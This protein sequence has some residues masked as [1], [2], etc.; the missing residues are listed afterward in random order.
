MIKQ[1]KHKININRIPALIQ[2]NRWSEQRGNSYSNRQK[3]EYKQSCVNASR[4]SLH[5]SIR[6]C[7]YHTRTHNH[8]ENTTQYH[9]GSILKNGAKQQRE[10][11]GDAFDSL[12]FALSLSLSLSHFHSRR[13]ITLLSF[14]AI[15]HTHCS[16]KGRQRAAESN[17]IYSTKT[18]TDAL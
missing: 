9:T 15:T 13:R 4:L 6:T 16:N 18:L 10:H 5:S 3:N 14:F 1:K 7:S 17:G 2:L 11:Y 12:F 8:T